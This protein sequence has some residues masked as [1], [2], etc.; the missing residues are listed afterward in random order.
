MFLIKAA[1]VAGNSPWAGEWVFLPF[2]VYKLSANVADGNEAV[3]SYEEK[4]ANDGAPRPLVLD[5]VPITSVA[6]GGS[7]LYVSSGNYVRA[8]ITG[9]EAVDVRANTCA[10]VKN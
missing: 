7:H 5:D 10:R 8:T 1:A 6:G 2:G 9:G 3:T 4:D